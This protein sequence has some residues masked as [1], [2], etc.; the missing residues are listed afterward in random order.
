MSVLGTDDSE[1]K[2]R[3][4]DTASLRK[5]GDF[6]ENFEKNLDD[7]EFESLPAG[8]QVGVPTVKWTR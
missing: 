8:R 4:P 1:F 5:P 3:R 7:P 2:S 6:R